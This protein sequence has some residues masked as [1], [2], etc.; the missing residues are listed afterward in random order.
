MD[1]EFQAGALGAGVVKSGFTFIDQERDQ[2]LHIA[3]TASPFNNHN[4]L[5]VSVVGIPANHISWQ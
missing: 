4:G 2:T 1:D 3:S 5:T